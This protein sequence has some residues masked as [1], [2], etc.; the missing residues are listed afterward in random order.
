MK[1]IYKYL[2]A[3]LIGVFVLIG[4]FH[5]VSANPF[6]FVPTVQTATAT[7]TTFAVGTTTSTS[8]IYD[9][10]NTYP[11]ATER[12]VLLVQNKPAITG[13]VLNIS[14]TYSQDCVDY[15]ED[16]MLSQTA[17]TPGAIAVVAS[18]S[19]TWVSTNAASTSKAFNMPTPTRC[20][21]A[22]FTGSNSTSSIWAQIV[23]Q[24]Q[25][26]Q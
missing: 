10:Y 15:Y 12:A 4:V 6:A 16:D 8:L 23:P 3:G 17:T 14:Y 13:A 2:G 5:K 25:A 24:R 22:T 7:S 18:S 20:V 26:K 11:L 21:K 1:N 9:S 19:V